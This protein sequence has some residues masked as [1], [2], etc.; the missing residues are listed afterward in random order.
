MA[1]SR[2]H[3]LPEYRQTALALTSIFFAETSMKAILSLALV[4][5]IGG[6]TDASLASAADKADPVG[7]W[8]CEY[9]I[10]DQARTS[11]LTIK[12]DGDKLAGTMTWPDQKDEKLKDV[13]L[14]GSTLTFAATRKLMGME[15]PLTYK[16]TIDG[17]K[18]KGK[19]TSDRDGQKTEFEIAGTREKK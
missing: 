4:L 1:G 10:G 17:D 6:L 16:F 14:D 9:K 15:I 2:V 5:I 11:E 8:K 13:K 3:R 19:G 18:L 7:T 12:K